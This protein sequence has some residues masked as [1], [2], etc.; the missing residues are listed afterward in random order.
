MVE[1]IID[2]FNKI[3]K[4]IGHG[5]RDRSNLIKSIKILLKVM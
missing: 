2:I 1:K 4:S 3:H 5:G